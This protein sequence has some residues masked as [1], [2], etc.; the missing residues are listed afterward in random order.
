MPIPITEL[1]LFRRF[2]SPQEYEA[3][4]GRP[5][6]PFDPKRPIQAWFDPDAENSPDLFI[7]Y[8]YHMSRDGVIAPL[9]I[10]KAWATTPNIPSGAVSGIV[11]EVLP[12]LRRGLEPGEIIKK[13]PF[14]VSIWRV[15]ELEQTQQ[16]FT[17]ADRDLLRRI[18]RKL[19]V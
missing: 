15:D 2:N 9:T 12:P 8:P 10:P 16:G 4:T 3:E 11:L 6:P 18:A 5:C 17:N 19:G 14:G 1:Y 7:T 13:T